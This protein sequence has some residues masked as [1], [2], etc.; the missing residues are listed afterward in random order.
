MGSPSFTMEEASP[1]S[2]CIL[3]SILVMYSYVCP[4]DSPLDWLW[5]L[6]SFL[7]NNALDE[8]FQMCFLVFIFISV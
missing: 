5:R 6:T 4:L 3:I 8:I 1:A 2:I 7:I